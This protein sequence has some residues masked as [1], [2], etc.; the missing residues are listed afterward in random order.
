MK[1]QRVSRR[2]GDFA[3]LEVAHFAELCT[4]ASALCPPLALGLDAVVQH[5]RASYVTG[6]CLEIDGGG[7]N[8]K[9]R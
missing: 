3:S 2:S 7:S 8:A 6:Q 1:L 4:R 9:E 5:A